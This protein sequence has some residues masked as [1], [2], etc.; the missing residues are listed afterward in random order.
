MPRPPSRQASGDSGRLAL[1]TEAILWE[2]GSYAPVEVAV[3][4]TADWRVHFAPWW[5]RARKEGESLSVRPLVAGPLAGVL[6]VAAGRHRARVRLAAPT[7]VPRSMRRMAWLALALGVAGVAAHHL[8]ASVPDGW[9]VA[10]Q[11]AAAIFVPSLAIGLALGVWVG[12]WA[13]APRA[14]FSAVL[15]FGVA[16]MVGLGLGALYSTSGLGVQV[17]PW[18]R[19]AI[20]AMAFAVFGLVAGGVLGGHRVAP[21]S[22]WRGVVA[23]VVGMGVDMGLS[24]IGRGWDMGLVMIPA[25]LWVLAMGWLLKPVGESPDGRIAPL[26]A[27]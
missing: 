10:A 6:V 14:V 16:T 23:G 20:G 25:S 15:G 13:L 12:G 21:A 2:E 11:W 5:V 17:F 1:S 26:G 22:A 9:P 19:L 7:T 3:Y 24:A 8:A 27:P 4:T 18:P